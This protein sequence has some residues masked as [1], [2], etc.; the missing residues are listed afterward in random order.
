MIEQGYFVNGGARAPGEETVPE[1]END[2]A[3]VL[4]EFF[5]S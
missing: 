5:Y 3:I 1:P 4:K 2:E